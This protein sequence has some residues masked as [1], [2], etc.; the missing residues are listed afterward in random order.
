MLRKISAELV[1]CSFLSAVSWSFMKIIPN[2]HH[3]MQEN[4][5]GL[6]LAKMGRWPAGQRG[7]LM[8]RIGVPLAKVQKEKRRMLQQSLVLT[9]A[10]NIIYKKQAQKWI[11]QIVPQRLPKH[12][13]K[14]QIT[15]TK[16][17][18]KTFMISP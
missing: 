13:A 8:F 16:S 7:T 9:Q 18:I 6:C 5:N 17:K 1:P 14:E 3:E 4:P 11:V 10:W 2:L 12:Q 15:E